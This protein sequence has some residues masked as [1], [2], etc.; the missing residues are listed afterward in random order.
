MNSNR[1]NFVKKVTLA[2]AY[3]SF[4]GVPSSAYALNQETE[5]LDVNIFSKHLQ[6]LDYENTGQVA[7]QL[8]FSGVDLTVRPKGHVL[9]ESVLS[10]IHI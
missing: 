9:P 8:G 4:A 7:A 10:L 1:R 6:F 3:A 2:T 5:P